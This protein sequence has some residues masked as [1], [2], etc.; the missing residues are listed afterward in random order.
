VDDVTV[1]TRPS[2]TRA[3]VRHLRAITG[4]SGATGVAI[5]S[6]ERLRTSPTETSSTHPQQERRA[7][8]RRPDDVPYL[9]NLPIKR[10]EEIV[11]E[12]SRRRDAIFR[13]ALAF[14]D[15]I[16]ALSALLITQLVGGV[17]GQPVQL[18]LGALAVVIGSK[19]IGLYDREELVIGKVTLNETPALFQLATFYTLVVTVLAGTSS[20]PFSPE[21]IV[22]LWATLF[23][24]SVIARATARLICRRT[25]APERCLVLGD[26]EQ[27]HD[28]RAK[29]GNHESIHGDVIAFLPFTTFE[30]GRERDYDFARYVIERNINRVIVTQDD[31]S[32]RVLE[33][34]RYFKEYGLKVSVLPNIL[35]VVGSSVEFDEIHGTTMLGVRSFGLSRSSVWLK[36]AFDLVGSLGILVLSSPVLAAI[37]IAIKLDSSGPVLFAQTRV[38]QDGLRFRI[39]K[40][41]TMFDGAD[42]MRAELADRNE[43]NGLFK[44][45][46]DP[47]VTRVGKFLR[48]TSL[49]ELP[50]LIN[51]VRGEMSLVG[52]RPLVEDEDSQVEGWHRR[53]LQLMPGITGAWQIMGDTRVPLRE[54]VMMDYLYIVNWSLWSDVKILIRTFGHVAGRRGL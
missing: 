16:G 39:Y 10:A 51:V 24:C 25:T 7:R 48:R 2:L 27:A 46:D 30:L 18:Y 12:R 35:Q 22:L 28:V 14:A 9:R 17:W 49:D 33:T 41:R 21:T 47:R 19:A 29:F 54:M 32:E 6:L 52:P 45:K 44:I 13:R 8:D 31:S 4:S 1:R 37:A 5:P 40:F 38:G 26:I 53:R 43:T 50:Q 42:R 23:V 34:V 36:R 3:D 15:L 11:T 20:N